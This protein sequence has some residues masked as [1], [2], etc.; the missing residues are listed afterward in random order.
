MCRR[1]GG[2]QVYAPAASVPFI[3][4]FVKAEME[5]GNTM[6]W[7]KLLAPQYSLKGVRG[8]DKFRLGNDYVVEVFDCVHS[9]PC[10]GFGISRIR[11]K[12]LPEYAG[13]RGAELGVLRKAGVELQEVVVTPVFAYLGDTHA[14]I[15]KTYPKLLT[16]PTIFCEC[17]FLQGNEE[18]AKAHQDG[19]VHWSE[20]CPVVTAN[21]DCTFVLHHFSMRYKEQEITDFFAKQQEDLSNVVLVVCDKSEAL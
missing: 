8:G 15:F 21:K 11:T 14:C 12:L 2:V 9:V 10:V 17:T 6:P 4:A 13:M 7:E 20:L 1:Q 18:L 16:F 5:M 3:D 19:H